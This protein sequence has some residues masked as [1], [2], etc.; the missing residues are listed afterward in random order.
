[1][2][3]SEWLMTWVCLSLNFVSSRSMVFLLS[4]SP[5]HELLQVIQSEPVKK[6]I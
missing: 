1:M 2:K 3:L 5:A 4:S 6:V